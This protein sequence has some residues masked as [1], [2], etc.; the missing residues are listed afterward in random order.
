MSGFFQGH[1]QQPDGGVCAV[2]TGI[3]L[4]CGLDGI[5][6]CTVMLPVTASSNPEA[7]GVLLIEE[8][9]GIADSL[10]SPNTPRPNFSGI[11]D[12][13]FGVIGHPLGII[14]SLDI[15]LSRE[16]SQPTQSKPVGGARRCTTCSPS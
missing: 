6:Q 4:S 5:H 15:V 11:A 13:R 7:L 14:R 8:L 3:Q 9:I 12:S 10:F 2:R 16:T 1:F